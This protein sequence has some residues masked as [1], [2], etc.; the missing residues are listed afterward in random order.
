MQTLQ[1]TTQ[2]T[3]TTISWLRLLARDRGISIDALARELR[4]TDALTDALVDWM[5]KT[6]IQSASHALATKTPPPA[7][8]DDSDL[9]TILV[10]TWYRRF[11][12]AEQRRLEDEADAALTRLMERRTDD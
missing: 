11:Q 8:D 6:A 12:R 7:P 4:T 5:R 1:T 10:H 9:L 3:Q 2:T